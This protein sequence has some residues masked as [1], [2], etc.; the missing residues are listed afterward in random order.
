MNV[1]SLLLLAFTAIV[2]ENFIFSQ[3]YGIC[4]FL[5]VSNKPSTA[6]GMGMAVTCVI[7]LSSF[8]TW[9]LYHH[10]LDP[11]GI[12]YLSTIAFI[13]VIAALVQLIEMFLKKYVPVLYE[14]LGIYLPLITTNC[15]VLVFPPLWAS[16]WLCSFS[17]ACGNVLC[18]QI[19]LN[20]LKDCL[21]C[22]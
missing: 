19:L 18:L 8:L 11:L 13:V 17:P 1:A 16:P 15:A 4:P 21:F 14:A 22:L 3:F 12:S 2:V 7:T 10:I 6:F 20:P 5:G 9:L